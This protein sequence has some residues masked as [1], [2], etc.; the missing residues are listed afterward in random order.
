MRGIAICP[1]THRRKLSI[2]LGFDV[3]TRVNGRSNARMKGERKSAGSMASTSPGERSKEISFIGLRTRQPKTRNDLGR[4]DRDRSFRVTAPC[5]W[6]A[7][8]ARAHGIKMLWIEAQSA[9]ISNLPS[10]FDVIVADLNTCTRVSSC[11]SVENQTGEKEMG[12]KDMR[13]SSSTFASAATVY[14]NS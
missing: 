9:G 11:R 3:R 2:G 13:F 1:P 12:A 10:N 5:A 7:R 8:G 4:K 6:R 14:L